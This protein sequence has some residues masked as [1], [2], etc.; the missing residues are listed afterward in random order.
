MTLLRH[1]AHLIGQRLFGAAFR[2][3]NTQWKEWA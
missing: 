1:L 2:E 3:L